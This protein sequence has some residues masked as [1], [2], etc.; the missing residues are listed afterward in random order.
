MENAK[1]VYPLGFYLISIVCKHQTNT[2]FVRK[3]TSEYF[4]YMARFF[5]FFNEFAFHEM[6]TV[7]A[8][9]FAG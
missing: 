5:L 2:L 8:I 7:V 1:K 9:L 4:C 6:K 3:Y